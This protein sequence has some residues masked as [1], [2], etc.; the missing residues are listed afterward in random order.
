MN[1]ASFFIHKICHLKRGKKIKIV[2]FQLPCSGGKI[3]RFQFEE[4]KKLVSPNFWWNLHTECDLEKEKIVCMEISSPTRKK[5][6]G[7]SGELFS[8]ELEVWNPIC[9]SAADIKKKELSRLSACVNLI[10]KDYFKLQCWLFPE[11]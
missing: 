11:W 7:K 1:I 2:Y 4:K 10:N 8:P 5:Y 6:W 3:P 9:L